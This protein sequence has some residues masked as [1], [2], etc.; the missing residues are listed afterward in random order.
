MAYFGYVAERLN[1]KQERV[2]ASKPASHRFPK[3]YV[4]MKPLVVE[5]QRLVPAVV[6][7]YPFQSEK[8]AVH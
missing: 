5:S 6:N 4:K 3:A 2:V 8:R 7:A 1:Y